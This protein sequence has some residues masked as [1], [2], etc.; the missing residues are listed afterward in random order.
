MT[1][2]DLKTFVR[3]HTQPTALDIETAKQ[4]ILE[5]L[6]AIS[7]PS[8]EP[9]ESQNLIRYV[10]QALFQS[11]GPLPTEY[12]DK[13]EPDI[14]LAK[15]TIAAREALNLLHAAGVLIAFGQRLRGHTEIR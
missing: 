9:V 1:T 5:R 6:D 15:A 4:I 3:E 2:N 11:S 14:N 12:I 8:S 7:T 13:A 10:E